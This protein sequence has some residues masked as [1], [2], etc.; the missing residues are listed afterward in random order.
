MA[1]GSTQAQSV[2]KIVG[3]WSKTTV[4]VKSN[5]LV[6]SQLDP[7]ITDVPKAVPPTAAGILQYNESDLANI[8]R[9]LSPLELKFIHICY[10][11]YCA[12]VFSQPSF[13]YICFKGARLDHR[14]EFS[15]LFEDFQVLI[16][17][18]Y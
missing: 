5:L 11:N 13:L 12:K 14:K 15:R 9:R 10:L 16:L 3:I 8:K 18:V 2:P 7:K 1:I 4:L 17:F 6:G